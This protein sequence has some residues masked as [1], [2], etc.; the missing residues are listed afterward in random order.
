MRFCMLTLALVVFTAGEEKGFSGDVGGSGSL[1]Q[2]ATL[3]ELE[4][5]L[6]SGT[7]LMV[8]PAAIEQ[9]LAELDE[10]PPDWSIVYGHG[11][12]DPGHD[13]RLFAL[14]RER[15]AKRIGR[16]A[17][18]KQVA[19]AW[20]GTLSRYD[21]A[22]GGHPVAIGPKFIRTSWGMVRFKA[23]EPP[24]NL[25]ATVEPANESRLQRLLE[26]DQPVE[27]EVVMTG[28]LIPE[29]SIVYDF[30]HDEEGLGL[31]MPFVRVERVD[32]VMLPPDESPR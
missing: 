11:H 27:I 8:H 16:P 22:I 2:L 6:P 23:E 3:H 32:F 18:S 30:S 15:D 13:D 10:Q 26:K 24:G 29:E 17:L 19:F 5:S 9:F 4:A 21:A 12:H 31:I 14:N 20:T 1:R 25:I 28:R 7:L